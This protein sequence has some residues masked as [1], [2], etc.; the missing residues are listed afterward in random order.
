[1][2]ETFDALMSWIGRDT[3]GARAGVWA[4]NSPPSCRPGW[5]APLA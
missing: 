1:M 2:M 4:H 5:S 3:G